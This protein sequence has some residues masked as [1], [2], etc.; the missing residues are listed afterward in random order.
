[1]SAAPTRQQFLRLYRDY[2]NTA[3]SFVSMMKK[4]RK[5]EY[6]GGVCMMAN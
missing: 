4:K 6:A 1:M 2:L 5:E 3:Q